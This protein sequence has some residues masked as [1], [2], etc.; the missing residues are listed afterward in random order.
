LKRRFPTAIAIAIGLL[1]LLSRFFPNATLTALG[2]FF[3]DSAIIVAAFAIIL[4]FFNLMIVHFKK[5]RRRQRDWPYSIILIVTM[6][7]VLVAGL[8]LDNRG[9]DASAVRWIFQYV[10]FP[11]QATIASLLAFFVASAAYRAFRAR[12]FESLLMLVVG[13][14]VLLGQTPLGAS[15]WDQLPAIK[16]WILEVPGLAGARGIILGVSLGTIA[17]GLRILLGIDR[18]Y[19]E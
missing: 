14:I 11:I 10:Q 15:M 17:T 12:N 6:W 18:P 2:Y 1:V 9:A 7:I 19:S 16:D 13:I 5:I 4:G 8:L 3:I